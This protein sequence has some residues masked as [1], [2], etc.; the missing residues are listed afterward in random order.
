M[1]IFCALV[2]AFFCASLAFGS[3]NARRGWDSVE[4]VE[5]YRE[6]S[7]LQFNWAASALARLHKGTGSESV[8]D[9]GSGDGKISSLI[10]LTSRHVLG[11]DI[12]HEMVEFAQFQFGGPTLSFAVTGPEL[13]E[14]EGERFD[15][16]TSFSAFHLVDNPAFI[17]KRFSELLDANGSLLILYPALRGDT[18]IPQA[19]RKVFS[20]RGIVPSARSAESNMIVRQN[21]ESFAAMVSDAGFK[22]RHFAVIES[23]ERFHSKRMLAAWIAGTIPGNMNIPVAV[24]DEIAD[25]ICSEFVTSNPGA[26]D[27]QG[28]ITVSFRYVETLA[29]KTSEEL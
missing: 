28:R 24:R 9:F 27:A 20:R 16:I 19:Y 11:A 10:A 8:L 26:I 15:A 12:S 7:Q 17:L 23:M 25:E 22:V 2:S 21:P 3:V 6:H 4:Q 18:A 29:Q 1:R 14:V 5:R 13:A